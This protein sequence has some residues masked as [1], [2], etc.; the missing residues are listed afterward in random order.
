MVGNTVEL[1][2]WDTSK[3]VGPMFNSIGTIANYP[4]WFLDV[5]VPANT[6]IQYK[7]FK[8]DSLGN[9]VWE[10]GNNHIYTTPS[11]TGEVIVNWQ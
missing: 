4:T 3:A 8:K 2:N 6:A 10:S 1:G 11:S 9:V 7:F 5:S